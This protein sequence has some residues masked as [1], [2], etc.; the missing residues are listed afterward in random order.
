ME[1][2]K[3]MLEK[4]EQDKS[5]RADP[6]FSYFPTDEATHMMVEILLRTINNLTSGGKHDSPQS[7][8]F[9]NV[10]MQVC[11][12]LPV[13]LLQGIESLEKEMSDIDINMCEKCRKEN[14]DTGNDYTCH[15]VRK[16]GDLLRCFMAVFARA[17]YEKLLTDAV[18]IA[19]GRL[20]KQEPTPNPGHIAGGV[21]AGMEDVVKFV[22]QHLK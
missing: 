7:M 17:G 5:Q 3:L 16:P 20:T 19:H 8:N 21:P 11:V 13:E 12:S 2:E 14:I 9:E 1:Q 15:G 10:S 4:V 22:K 6:T 18:Q